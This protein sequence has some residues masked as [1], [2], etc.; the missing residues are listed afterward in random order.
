M[1]ELNL[2]N[3]AVNKQRFIDAA[4]FAAEIA[5]KKV[6]AWN[7]TVWIWEITKCLQAAGVNL[8]D[9]TQALR[10][11]DIARDFS[12]LFSQLHQL[13]NLKEKQTEK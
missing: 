5:S 2:Y 10:I 9:Y 6:D 1:K 11:A 7:R 13:K 4:I 12:L 3:K 8:S